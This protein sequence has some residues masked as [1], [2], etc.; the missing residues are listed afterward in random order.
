MSLTNF[1]TETNPL[2]DSDVGECN[3]VHIILISTGTETE[4]CRRVQKDRYRRR[5][6][7]LSNINFDDLPAH[8]NIVISL[9]AAV[10]KLLTCLSSFEFFNLYSSLLSLL[11][12]LTVTPKLMGYFEC[13]REIDMSL[14]NIVRTLS[15]SN[16]KP[17][18]CEIY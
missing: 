8:T 6:R 7:R 9:Y 15:H 13:C 3:R 4:R 12:L 11:K 1:H 16:Y 14:H 17:D 10:E 5:N 2:R 18:T